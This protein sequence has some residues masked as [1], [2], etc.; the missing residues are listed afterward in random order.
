MKPLSSREGC[1]LELLF[2]FW[3]FLMF[4]NFVSSAVALPLRMLAVAL[5]ALSSSAALA[6]LVAEGLQFPVWLESD[7]ERRALAPGV[8]M[9]D[10]DTVVTGDGGKVWLRMEDGALV[11]LGEGA[12]LALKRARTEPAAD[13]QSVST[14]TGSASSEE[15]AESSEFMDAAFDVLKG[16]FRYTTE[17][18]EQQWR[19]DVEIGLGLTT[20]I[21]IRGTDLWGRVDGEN[22][23][24][25]LLE[26]RIEVRPADA[27]TALVMDVPLQIFQA[28]EGALGAVEMAQVQALAPQTELDNG[29]G[30]QTVDGPFALNLASYSE[31]SQAD[32]ARLRASQAGLAASVEPVTVDG[33]QWYRLVVTGLAS[34]DG[35]RS[36]GSELQAQF[37][38]SSPWVSG[39]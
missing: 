36:L 3:G 2:N 32:A 7:G 37:G 9:E 16:A 27:G 19:R 21:G 31:Q 13:A 34:F 20:T 12:E 24:V 11:K 18:L 38:Y 10:G 17:K 35:A 25:V 4:G 30:V 33:E 22:N 28:A 26:G 29:S 8:K 5:L 14:A 1:Y 23:F 6:G 15:T 39:G